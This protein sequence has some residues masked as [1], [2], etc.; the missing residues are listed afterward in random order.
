MLTIFISFVNIAVVFSPNILPPSFFLYAQFMERCTACTKYMRK[1][2]D[3]PKFFS[4]M[5]HSLPP[6]F[7]TIIIM[8]LQTKFIVNHSQ[9]QQN[10][11]KTCKMVINTVKMVITKQCIKKNQPISAW[12]NISR[13][14]GT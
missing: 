5:L 14:I 12:A 9:Q 1:A 6:K 7:F 2:L 10:S 3:S 4:P 13:N 11:N 8:V